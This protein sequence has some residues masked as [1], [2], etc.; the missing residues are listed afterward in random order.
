MHYGFLRFSIK[1]F[2]LTFCKNKN[3]CLDICPKQIWQK[4]I[5]C[6]SHKIHSVKK[7]LI[8]KISTLFLFAVFV[9]HK[10]LTL[11]N[12]TSWIYLTLMFEA[13]YEKAWYIQLNNFQQVV[14]AFDLNTKTQMSFVLRLQTYIES[15]EMI[16][17]LV[18]SKCDWH[19]N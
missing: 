19:S 1:F 10:I 12:K 3:C 2:F 16:E 4:Q 11:Q 8:H 7:L 18:D 6:I 14:V 13:W 15:N 17:I 5:F 9:I